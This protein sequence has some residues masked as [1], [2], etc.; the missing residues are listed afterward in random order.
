VDL[1]AWI[2]VSLKRPFRREIESN[3][4][5]WLDRSEYTDI[6]PMYTL[7]DQVGGTIGSEEA[8][9]RY[10]LYRIRFF[11]PGGHQLYGTTESPYMLDEVIVRVT[12]DSDWQRAEE[13]LVAAAL[14]VTGEIIEATGVQPYIRAD[15]Y[16]YGIYLR[17][18]YQCRV[19][20]A[21]KSSMS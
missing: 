8:V 16:D 11:Q 1:A 12:F 4:R 21:L 20:N 17:L 2:L 10:I 5:P 6:G 15:P 3:S 19:Q 14:E 9:G 13:I 7:L 18:R